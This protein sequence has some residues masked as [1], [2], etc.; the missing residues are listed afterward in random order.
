IFDPLTVPESA[1]AAHALVTKYLGERPVKAVVYSHAH[2]DHFG[3]VKGVISQEQVDN[4]EVQ[5]IAPRDFMEHV[6][7]ETVLAGNAMARRSSY[8]Y[9]IMMPKNKYGVVDGAL[10]KGVPTGLV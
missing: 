2:V 1:K 8:Q 5:V 7:K 9:G 4:G 3:G 6:V 10:G